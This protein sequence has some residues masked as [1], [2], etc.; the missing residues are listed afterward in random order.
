VFKAAVKKKVKLKS[1]IIGP[2][3]SGKTM[4]ALRLAA[5]IGNKIAVID[6]E[7]GSAALYSD[8]IAF[9][10]LEVTA[11][12]TVNKYIDA[13]NAAVA[14]GYE[15]LVIDS[16]THCWSGEGG[17]LSEKEA[18]DSRGGNSFTNWGSITKKHELFKA[19][20]LNSPIHTICTMRSKQEYIIESTERG[21]QA[22]RKVGMAP[23]QRDG[24]EYEFTV[25]LDVGVDH[26]AICSKDRTGIFDGFNG[27][28]TEV[29]GK[30]LVEWL[31]SG[32]SVKPDSVVTSQPRAK[33][34]TKPTVK[35][36][37]D[38]AAL[39]VSKGLSQTEFVD[40]FK[41]FTG[42]QTMRDLTVEGAAAFRDYLTSLTHSIVGVAE[43]MFGASAVR[44]TDEP[45]SHNSTVRPM[46][47][48]ETAS[49]IATRLQKAAIEATMNKHR[50]PVPN[51]QAG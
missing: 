43:D 11:P 9:D 45:Q 37:N 14:G 18:L 1:A 46:V 32:S 5:G 40:T 44:V 38:L 8:K 30:K 12:Y 47:T 16:I 7:N 10:T 41:E 4:S 19:A 23:I 29:T 28:I 31:D 25:V 26:T 22:P 6:T 27:V 3:G 39:G 35:E 24:M 36:L 21:K 51:S 17:L 48:P 49:E 13:I 20:L 50:L 15:V 2:S 42:L 33:D 34:T